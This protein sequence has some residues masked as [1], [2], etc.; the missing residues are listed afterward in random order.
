MYSSEVRT[1]RTLAVLA[2]MAVF[3]IASVSAS[4]CDRTTCP[5]GPVFLYFEHDNCTGDS[6]F[7]SMDEE[8]DVCRSVPNESFITRHRGTYIEDL[9]YRGSTDCGGGRADAVISGGTVYYF[10]TCSINSMLRKGTRASNY[11]GFILLNNVNDTYTAPQPFVVDTAVPMIGRRVSEDCT[12]AAD[13]KAKGAV[14]FQYYD[15]DTCVETGSTF[16][17]QTYPEPYKCYRDSNSYFMLG[18]QGPHTIE[19]IYY[20]DSACTRPRYSY[21]NGDKC[22]ETGSSTTSCTAVRPVIASSASTFQPM[23]IFYAALIVLAMFL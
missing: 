5:P 13:C 6:Y 3:S 23:A 17:A 20:L 2:I 9:R 22:G 4:T 14:Y 8:F 7:Y 15:N 11:Y 16:E 1:M 12:S 19:R 18:C 21:L 10:G